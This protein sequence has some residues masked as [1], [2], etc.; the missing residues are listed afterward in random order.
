[1]KRTPSLWSIVLAILLIVTLAR[2]DEQ[3][4]IWDPGLMPPGRT[5]QRRN[6]RRNRERWARRLAYRRRR[7]PFRKR[8]RKRTVKRPVSPAVVL[9]HRGQTTVRPSSKCRTPQKPTSTIQR[10]AAEDPLAD[11]HQSRG[12]IDLVDERKLWEMLIR[13]LWPNGPVCPHCGERD[14]HYLKEMIVSPLSV[15]E[16]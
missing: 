10:V 15:V 1:M 14:L 4:L 13:I 7:Q 12:L 6:P 3:M 8:E 2:A 11:L 5:R 16:R 9:Q